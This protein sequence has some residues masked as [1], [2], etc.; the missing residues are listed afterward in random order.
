MDFWKTVRLNSL[1]KLIL[2]FINVYYNVQELQLFVHVHRPIQH[3]IPFYT[4][5]IIENIVPFSLVCLPC[6]IALIWFFPQPQDQQLKKHIQT[7]WLKNSVGISTMR[8]YV[9][10]KL[11]CLKLTVQFM[12]LFFSC[13]FF[14]IPASFSIKF[15]IQKTNLQKQRSMRTLV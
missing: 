3:Q 2:F 11:K 6:K 10:H 7:I 8:D 9:I 14:L 15:Y 5:Q 12:C 4:T 1:S 13:F